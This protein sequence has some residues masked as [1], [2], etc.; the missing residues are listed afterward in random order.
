MEDNKY[1]ITRTM[2]IYDF[3]IIIYLFT[4]AY[5]HVFQSYEYFFL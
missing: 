3:K 1:E 2:I 4:N 5:K